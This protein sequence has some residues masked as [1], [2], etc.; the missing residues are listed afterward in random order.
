MNNLV[1]LG[2]RPVDTTSIQSSQTDAVKAIKV[3]DVAPPASLNY[4]SLGK[5][6]SIRNQGFC[7]SC[8]AFASVAYYESQLLI[9]GF[10]Y[11]LS[12]EASL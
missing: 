9:R 4:D 1:L 8:W 6:T 10:N 5:V 12:D 2:L 11:E 3:G 7:G